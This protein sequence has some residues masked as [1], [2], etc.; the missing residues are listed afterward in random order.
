[1]KKIDKCSRN[2]KIR[3]F[4]MWL[5][6]PAVLI[7][8]S[9]AMT[10]CGPG[11]AEIDKEQ[12]ALWDSLNESQNIS[13]AN[14]NL[15]K[16]RAEDGNETAMCNLGYCYQKG[17]KVDQDYT[18]AFNW[19]KKAADKGDIKGQNLTSF[20]YYE[21]VGVTKDLNNAVEY[22]KKAADQ[23]DP[24]SIVNLGNLYANEDNRSIYDE[25]K[26]VQLFQQAAD[27]GHGRG[28][29]RLSYYYLFGRGG[30]QKDIK[31]GI[32]LM[33]Q[34]AE[35]DEVSAC[36]L[37]SELYLAKDE[38][39]V[40]HD[41]EKGIA[42]LEKAANLGDAESQASLGIDYYIGQY[43]AKDEK[44]AAQWFRKAAEQ[45]NPVGM[46]YQGILYLNGE[47]GYEENADSARHYLMN[48]ALNG[49]E[50]A[51]ALLKKQFPDGYDH[52]VGVFNSLNNLY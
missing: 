5:I 47:C 15:I 29:F 32:E 7:I 16:Q 12:S 49:N 41:P 50:L 27:L 18:Q 38:E 31:K 21:G 46:L 33:T 28:L 24:E 10:G 23:K 1:M 13:E 40:P 39:Y 30:L 8:A 22:L 52:V 3:R 45:S 6:A 25:S 26:A 19:Y 42:Y 9:V 2:G 35:K 4:G 43:V 34:A 44:K 14:F 51:L 37:L 20:C 17:I 11:K 48:S 36:T